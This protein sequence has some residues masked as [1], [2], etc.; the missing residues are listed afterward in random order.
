MGSAANSWRAV[1]FSSFAGFSD[2]FFLAFFLTGEFSIFGF[3]ML[4]SGRSY[5]MV[6][7]MIRNARLC[8]PA[9]LI[10]V[11]L[12]TLAP[13][14]SAEVGPAELV[15]HVTFRVVLLGTGVGPPVN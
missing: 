15:S 10:C 1:N 2:P 6:G 14:H 5:R 13:T 9:I 8:L 11:W 3:N 4:C 7:P 12:S